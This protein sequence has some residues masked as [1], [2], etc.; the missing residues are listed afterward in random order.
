MD[1]CEVLMWLGRTPAA[2]VKRYREGVV[3]EIEALAA[4]LIQ[5]GMC[6]DWMAQCD[7]DMRAVAAEVNGPLMEALVG[8]SS[9]ADTHCPELFREGVC[10]CAAVGLARCIGSACTARCPAVGCTRLL[11]AWGTAGARRAQC[12]GLLVGSCMC[13]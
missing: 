8:R 11:W 9:H 6:D 3:S 13:L 7:D 4:R 2:E 1:V 5:S 10:S 12:P